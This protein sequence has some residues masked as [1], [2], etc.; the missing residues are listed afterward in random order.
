MSRK[1][2]EMRRAPAPARSPAPTPPPA[3]AP[4]PPPV[5]TKSLPAPLPTKITVEDVTDRLLAGR[6]Q[7]PAKSATPRVLAAGAAVVLAVGLSGFLAWFAVSGEYQYAGLT[8][9]G[10][11]VLGV[12]ARRLFAP[13]DD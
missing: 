1:K 5:A 10:L 12:A 13:P 2:K 6:L 3:A 4:T 8:A 11:L 9:A 7:P